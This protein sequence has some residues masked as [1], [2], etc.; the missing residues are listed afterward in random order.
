[1]ARR[2]EAAAERG[3]Y[4]ALK[5]FRLVEKQAKA[6]Q[7]S[8]EPVVK[9][10]ELGSFFPGES[11]KAILDSLPAEKPIS[12]AKPAPTAPISA[13]RSSFEVPISIG[14]AG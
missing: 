14:R 4:R 12:P 6:R 11:M 9:T 10:Q 2:H 8:P 3:F 13:P 7:N 5:E 1:M